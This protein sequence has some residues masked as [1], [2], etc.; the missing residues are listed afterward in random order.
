M[1][2]ARGGQHAPAKAMLANLLC[3]TPDQP[4]ALQ[5]LGMIARQCGDHESAITLFRHS[6]AVNP[7]QPHVLNNL[8][9]SLTDLA[10]HDQAAMAYRAA[11]QMLPDHTDALV[12]LGLA[13]LATGDAT[14]ARDTLR[15]ATDRAPNDARAWSVLG[16]ALRETGE[17]DVAISAFDHSL[18][19]RPDHVAT[20]HNLGVTYRLGGR[21]AAALPLF[22]RCLVWAAE[23]PEIHYNLGH[24]LQDLGQI[25]AAADAYRQAIALRP[26][27]R[28]AHDSL[29]RMLWQHRRRDNYLASYRS[30]LVLHPGDQ[31]LLADLARRMTLGAQAEDVVALLEHITAPSTEVRYELGRAYWTSGRSLAALEQFRA[32]LAA[33][34]GFAPAARDLARAL[35]I[36]DKPVEALEAIAPVLDVDPADQQA[37]AL[38]G[39][40]WRFTDDP[41]ECWLNDEARLVSAQLL[42]PP[43]G[44]VAAFNARLDGALTCLH[45]AAGHPLEQT[46]RGG[47]QTT[48]DLFARDL[49]DVTMVRA[50]IE[51]D[52]R[53]YI[54]ALPDDPDH[55]FLGRKSRD[56]AFA[57]SWSVR[58][59]RSGFHENH[60]HP[61]GWISAAYYVSL[62]DAVED[63]QQGWLKFGETGLRLGTRERI[64][65]LVRP[66][67]GL[68]VLFPSYLYHGTIP[69]EDHRHRTTIAFDVVPIG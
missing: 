27:D 54:A 57:G 19:L 16:Q 5:L 4:D 46:L 7:T 6:L 39:L 21:P 52:I 28:A 10:Q 13:L 11:L 18:A 66:E 53:R 1:A 42:V 35:I 9:N 25:D 33:D 34:P 26:T 38:R 63:G 31:G 32:A 65:Q 14:A 3:T 37:W 29:N 49:P 61:E 56:F 30:A 59:R 44:D 17:L 12:N 2:L 36:L 47:T 68:L 24:C 67:P 23:T 40:G 58:L 8:G 55:P 50:M 48:D 60:I 15:I 64:T 45:G 51:T 41:R 62:P 20:L 22:H 69:F 43:D